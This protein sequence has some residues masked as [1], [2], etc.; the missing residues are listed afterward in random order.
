MQCLT[1]CNMLLQGLKLFRMLRDDSYLQ[2]MLSIV[3]S[4]YTLHVLPAQPP[5]DNM[6]FQLQS[7][8]AFLHSTMNVAASAVPVAYFDTQQL[9]TA[10]DNQQLILE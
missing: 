2:A 9:M 7:Y 3:S 6:F 4:F 8:Q 5:P 1:I 10:S